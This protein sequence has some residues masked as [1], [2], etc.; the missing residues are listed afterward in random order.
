MPLS[1][2]A[3]KYAESGLKLMLDEKGELLVTKIVS[4]NDVLK[5]RL[6]RMKKQD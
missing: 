5:R 3:H 6:E 1:L 4:E 2:D